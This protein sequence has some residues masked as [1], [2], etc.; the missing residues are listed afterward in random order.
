MSVA[1]TFDNKVL[2]ALAAIGIIIV[3]SALVDGSKDA[4]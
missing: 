3:H 2:M 1:Y 4:G